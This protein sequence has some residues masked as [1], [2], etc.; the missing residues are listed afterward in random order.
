M[1]EFIAKHTKYA[2]PSESTIRN[3]CLPI[4]HQECIDKMKKIAGNNYIWISVDETTDCEQRF[5]AN[6]IFGVL[7]D[8]AERGKSYLFASEVLETTNHSTI[9]TFVDDCVKELGKTV[10]YL[11]RF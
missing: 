6:F 2:A 7:G 11:G 5:V 10:F 9:A 4:L 3:K 1:A 8:E